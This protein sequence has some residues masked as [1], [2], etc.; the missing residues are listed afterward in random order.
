MEASKCVNE[1]K[2]EGGGRGEGGRGEGGKVQASSKSCASGI[3]VLSHLARHSGSH[4]QYGGGL[5]RW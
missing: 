3:D 1:M 5:W 4:Q 2:D